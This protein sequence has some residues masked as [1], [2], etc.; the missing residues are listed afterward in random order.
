MKS[1][2][3]LI[4]NF[5]LIT[6]LQGLYA[7]NQFEVTNIQVQES[8]KNHVEFNW[9]LPKNSEFDSFSIQIEIYD[10]GKSYVES[11]TKSQNNLLVDGL[12]PGTS[13][14]I[15]INTLKSALVL[16]SANFSTSTG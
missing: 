5:I 7:Q 1:H 13:L 4:F 3:H 9:T 15:T 14:K 11:K 8:D 12:E 10:T 2:L 16:A 6:P